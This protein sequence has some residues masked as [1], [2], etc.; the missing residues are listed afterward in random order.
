MSQPLRELINKLARRDLII[1]DLTHELYNG[2]PTYPGDPSFNHEYVKVGRNYGEATLSKISA[3]LHS[4]THIDLPRHF[5]PNGATAEALPLTDFITYGIILDLSYKGHGEAITEDDL[6]EFNDKIQGNYAVMLYTGFSKAWGT[7][8]FLY[9][10][11]YLDRS[12][13]DYLI[14]RG[15]K[16]VGIEALSIAG[17]PGKEGYP[18]P[19]RVPK[20]DVAYVH[21]RLLSNGIYIIE[22]V[23]NLDVALSTCKN[24]EGLFLFTPLKI[25][26][27]EGSPLRLI[28]I[29]E[30]K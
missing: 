11:P 2:M 17:W 6:R 14:K 22:G 23:A 28:M 19:P 8:E 21:H 18:Y 10:W 26:G 29:C 13:A 15:I 5:V 4:G 12:G 25:R 27:A 9:N 3:G 1:I 20:D 16:A 30:P 24:N 7:E